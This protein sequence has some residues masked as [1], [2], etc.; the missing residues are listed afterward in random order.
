ME[1]GVFSQI[2][3]VCRINQRRIEAVSSSSISL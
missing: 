3:R 2:R 1:L